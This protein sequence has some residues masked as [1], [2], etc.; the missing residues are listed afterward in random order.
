MK[1]FITSAIAKKCFSDGKSSTTLSD[2]AAKLSVTRNATGESESTPTFTVDAVSTPAEGLLISVAEMTFSNPEYTI[3]ST[4]SAYLAGA[5]GGT[6]SAPTS[7]TTPATTSTAASSYKITKSGSKAVITIV[8]A[9]ATT[10]KIYRKAPPSAIAK[11][12][13]SLSGK[14]GSNTYST[15]WK[16]G[17]VYIIRSI[18]GTTLA[19]LK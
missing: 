16:T 8:L 12:V 7:A 14:K 19:T 5:S 6:P 2:I 13:K 15:T 3:K 9:A 1:A 17:Y 10:V 11:L 18:Q 4:L